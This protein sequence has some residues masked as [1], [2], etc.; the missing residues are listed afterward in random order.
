MILSTY[1]RYNISSH[2]TN[3]SS[4]F[5]S[6]H[7]IK[8]LGKTELSGDPLPRYSLD[9]KIFLQIC[10]FPESEKLFQIQ[11]GSIPAGK[12]WCPGSREDSPLQSPPDMSQRSFLTI[13]VTFRLTSWERLEMTSRR[14]TNLTTKGHPRGVDSG[15]PPD[16]LENTSLE[17]HGFICWIPYISFYFSFGAYS[18]DKIYLKAIQYSRCIYNPVELLTWSFSYKICEWFLVASYFRERASSQKLKWVTAQ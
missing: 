9:R 16:I 5:C 15:R 4:H 12:Q 7:P 14:R 8:M 13:P 17:R 1:L 6:Q 3:D 11:S 18:T 10:N 2:S